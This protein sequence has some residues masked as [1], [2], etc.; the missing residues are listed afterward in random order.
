MGYIVDMENNTNPNPKPMSPDR[1]RFAMAREA[2]HQIN[3]GDQMRAIEIAHDIR[4]YEDQ[5][6]EV[7]GREVDRLL[8]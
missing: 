6:S 1:V 5:L 3:S 2:A 7:L 4:F 8:G